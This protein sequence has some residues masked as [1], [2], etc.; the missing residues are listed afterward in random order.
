[1]AGLTEAR[2]TKELH[3]GAVHYNYEREVAS[4]TIYAGALTAQNAAG[5][6]V[7]A[8]DAASL[9]VLGR[10]EATVAAGETLVIRRGAYLY[11]NATAT[12]EVLTVAD[13]GAGCF[14]IDDHTVG[15]VGGTNKIKVGIVLD[16]TDD[17]VAVLI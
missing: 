1:M 14:V 11:D 12:A 4:G 17:G 16:V 3:I 13:I 10:A 2:N 5:K 7:P 9:V 15:K 8:S 6:A